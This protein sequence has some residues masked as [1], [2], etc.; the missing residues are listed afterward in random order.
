MVKPRWNIKK[1]TKECP[2]PQSEAPTLLLTPFSTHLSFRW[3]LPLS[4]NRKRLLKYDKKGFK[5]QFSTLMP[6]SVC[7]YIVF[8][9]VR[10]CIC[11][12]I[13]TNTY[14]YTWEKDE[15]SEKK[16]IIQ[17]IATQNCSM[18]SIRIRNW[19]ISLAKAN[20]LFEMV[21]T[22]DMPSFRENLALKAVSD[23]ISGDW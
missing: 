12:Y 15:L 9:R 3:T 5:V 20:I 7:M 2:A 17:Q 13:Y 22:K 6:A 11:V 18:W 8:V 16:I 21:W 19:T 4:W 14:M 23:E 10:T 1:T